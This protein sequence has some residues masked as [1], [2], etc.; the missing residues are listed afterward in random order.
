MVITTNMNREEM[1]KLCLLIH[2]G[3]IEQTII[4][5]HIAMLI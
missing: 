1:N 2:V 5:F 4:I 3:W